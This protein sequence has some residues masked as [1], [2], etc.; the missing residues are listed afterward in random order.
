M[1]EQRFIMLLRIIA[2][3]LLVGA[4]FSTFLPD[5]RNDPG[6]LSGAIAVTVMYFGLW[7]LA[8][9]PGGIISVVLSDKGIGREERRRIASLCHSWCMVAAAA[10]TCRLLVDSHALVFLSAVVGTYLLALTVVHARP[11]MRRRR[12]PY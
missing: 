4:V 10:A 6:A 3:I 9:L 1:P 11:R 5:I 2:G 8:F 12:V 7:T